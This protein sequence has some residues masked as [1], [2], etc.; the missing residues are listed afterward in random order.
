MGKR[1]KSESSVNSHDSNPYI[2]CGVTKL[3]VIVKF[4]LHSVNFLNFCK[5]TNSTPNC[6]TITRKNVIISVVAGIPAGR[7]DAKKY[8]EQNSETP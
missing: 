6:K 7:I 8:K 3:S 5:V 4:I 1:L 2:V